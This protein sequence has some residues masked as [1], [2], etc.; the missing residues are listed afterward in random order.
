M[1]NLRRWTRRHW[2]I[3]GKDTHPPLSLEQEYL[4]SMQHHREKLL[5]KPNNSCSSV[6]QKRLVNGFNEI[7]KSGILLLSGLLYD[8]TLL[9]QMP[10]DG[11]GLY[12]NKI[13]TCTI[14]E[15]PQ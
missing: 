1:V 3:G 7:V 13:G 10:S 4:H 2:Q 15:A 8:E 5:K 9:S 6:T 14:M 11:R 12:N